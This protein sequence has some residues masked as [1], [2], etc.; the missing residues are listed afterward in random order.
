VF[1]RCKG[2]PSALQSRCASFV[3]RLAEANL[4]THPTTVLAGS[5][6]KEI[7]RAEQHHHTRQTPTV[8][9][10]Q[11]QPRPAATA[12]VL[13]IP[14]AYLVTFFRYGGFT[15]ARGRGSNGRPTNDPLARSRLCLLVLS[16]WLC[17]NDSGFS[18]FT[19][20]HVVLR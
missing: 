2:S 11:P 12:V 7:H 9:R 14:Q 3:C 4:L 19:P 17:P 20:S 15:T 13:A 16:I 8:P 18:S 5:W 1:L 10:R 6:R